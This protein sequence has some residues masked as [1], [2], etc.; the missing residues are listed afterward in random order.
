MRIYP[1]YPDENKKQE[2]RKHCDGTRSRECPH[3][4]TESYRCKRCRRRCCW[5]FGA[6]DD[7]PDHCDDCWA[8][9]NLP[10]VEGTDG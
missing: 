9:V 1:I 5:C 7:L 3:G 2:V 10:D 6:A 4:E 8:K